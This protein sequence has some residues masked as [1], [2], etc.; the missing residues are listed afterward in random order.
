MHTT[1]TKQKCQPSQVKGR[2]ELK[3]INFNLVAYQ[4]A[5]IASDRDHSGH[6]QKWHRRKYEKFMMR[7]IFF[8]LAAECG[9]MRFAPEMRRRQRL[10]A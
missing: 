8:V 2:K 10:F 3:F 4:V 7:Y 5:T 9:C 6:T 1:S